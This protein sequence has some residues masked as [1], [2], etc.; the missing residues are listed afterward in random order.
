VK[1]KKVNDESIDKLIRD[2]EEQKE[3]LSC[4]RERDMRK[5]SRDDSSRANTRELTM[6]I[7]AGLCI[8]A[9]SF[10]GT[11]MYGFNNHII[12]LDQ[13]MILLI[14]PD[15]RIVPSGK[16][17]SH[18]LARRGLEARIASLEERVKTLILEL[19]KLDGVEARLTQSQMVEGQ[20][21]LNI[22]R[23]E[24]Y[25]MKEDLTRDYRRELEQSITMIEERL[26][27]LYRIL[28][29]DGSWF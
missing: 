19:S 24:S 5:Q 11:E 15:F 12:E 3:L 2:L 20:S 9:I 21:H 22:L 7:V 27:N 14:T 13:K 4:N 23:T 25:K 10:M 6:R 17:T 1:G 18:E 28:T 8:A 29:E 16:H 26:E